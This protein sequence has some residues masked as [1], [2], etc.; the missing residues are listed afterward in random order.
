M[1]ARARRGRGRLMSGGHRTAR[2]QTATDAPPPGA[3]RRVSGRVVRQ[4][5]HDV[6][7]LANTWVTLHRVGSDTA[8]PMDSLRTDPTGRFTFRYQTRGALM[9]CY[10]VSSSYDGIAYFSSH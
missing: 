9:P 1:V 4:G 7:P 6:A 2:A 8:G 10:F 5:V 3:A